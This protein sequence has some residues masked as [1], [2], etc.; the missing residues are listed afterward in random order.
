MPVLDVMSRKAEYDC[1][2]VLV[3]MLKTLSSP[4]FDGEAFTTKGC[5]RGF[6]GINAMQIDVKVCGAAEESPAAAANLKDSPSIQC[7]ERLQQ[8]S[9]VEGLRSLGL[10][11]SPSL[12]ALRKT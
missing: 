9:P 6:I 10:H 12:R 11:Y 5:Q 3:G 1:I 4:E 2:E 7:N 8:F